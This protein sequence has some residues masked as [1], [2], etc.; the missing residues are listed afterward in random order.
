MNR[1]IRTVS[2]CFYKQFHSEQ[3]H[4]VRAFIKDGFGDIRRTLKG[5]QM[6]NRRRC[7]WKLLALVY[8]GGTDGFQFIAIT[9]KSL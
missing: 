9:Q 3:R 8:G 5:F 7:I 4:N 6:Y 1:N 2:Q